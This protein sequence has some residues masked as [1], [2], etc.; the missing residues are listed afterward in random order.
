MPIITVSDLT[1]SFGDVPVLA[2]V[3]FALQPGE[4]V[5]LVGRNG[6]GKTTL[7]RLLAG[8]EVPDRGSVAVRPGAT[9]GYL[10]QTPEIQPGHTLWD[11]A[12]SAFSDLR[13]VERRLADAEARLAAPDVHGDGA[14]LE[15]A[16]EEYGRLRDRFERGGGFSY[17]AEIRRTL[18][19]LG[20]RE[21]QWAQPLTSMSGGQRSRGALARLL[22]SAPDLLLLDEPTNHLDLDALEWLQEFLRQ[23]R[24]A[25]LLV[26]H[27]RYLLDSI[28]GRTLDLDDGRIEE[29]PGN[30]S[31]YVVERAARRAR[32]QEAFERQQEEIDSLQAYIRRYRAGQKSRQAKSREKRLAR[33]EPLQAPRTARTL[34]FRLD[35]P[36]RAPTTVLRARDIVKRYGADAV[37]RRIAVQVRRGEKVGLIGP[38]GTG[39]TTLLRILAGLEPPTAGTVEPGPGVRIGYFAQHA[40]ETMDPARTV[41]DEVLDRRPIT[42]EQARTLLGRFL[43]SKDSVYKTVG[44]LSGGERRR[45]ALAKLVLDRPDLLLLDEPTTH[46][47]LASLE[48]LEVALRAFPGAMILASHDRYLLEHLA[49]RLL[50]LTDGTITEVAGGYRAYRERLPTA[51][52]AGAQGGVNHA[53][54]DGGFV[55][56]AS[57]RVAYGDGQAT[58]SASPT[59]RDPDAAA[60][61]PRSR[62]AVRSA[63]E[64]QAPPD[65]ALPSLRPD[66]PREPRT[67]SKDLRQEP[68][69]PERIIERI[70]V[71]E[72][73]QRDLGRLMGDPELY[74]DASRARQTVQR[75]EEVSAGLAALYARLTSLEHRSSE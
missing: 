54:D 63:P 12:A 23:Y 53:V 20:F 72:E 75:Y 39:K 64:R 40:E 59:A 52:A 73:E 22:L 18:G 1:K 7:L 74:R 24:G 49:T 10:P 16:L 70:G 32:A 61:Q 34:S 60:Q 57:D 43:F 28:T 6:V 56:R 27:D 71:L 11:E 26:S 17:E 35:A 9:V 5:G 8:R 33:I 47:D 30:Y 13:E 25:A 36:R 58:R 14:R 15:A 45:V 29:Y 41:L 38:N 21:P 19:G 51:V 48:A 44:Q 55:R 46:L 42:P 68:E 66:V 4:K 2:G 67:R 69:T 62:S 3:S 31:C 37:L 50:V 65:G